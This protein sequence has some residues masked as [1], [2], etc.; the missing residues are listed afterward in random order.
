MNKNQY[1]SAIKKLIKDNEKKTYYF[2]K[3]TVIDSWYDGMVVPTNLYKVFI[4]KDVLYINVTDEY[5]PNIDNEEKISEWD[6]EDIEK[7]FE[8]VKHN[9]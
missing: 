4:K 5:H 7:I 6:V 9:K 8:L 2:A 1:I 3:D